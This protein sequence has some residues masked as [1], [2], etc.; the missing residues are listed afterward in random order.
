MININNIKLEYKPVKMQPR[1]NVSEVVKNYTGQT[2]PKYG[3]IWPKSSE[4]N[5]THVH[6]MQQ[7]IPL[8]LNNIHLTRVPSQPTVVRLICHSREMFYFLKAQNNKIVNTR[9]LK[10]TI[11]EKLCVKAL[12]DRWFTISGILCVVDPK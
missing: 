6:N 3:P 10:F 11:F 8:I 5:A 7:Y 9:S 2:R 4:F 12:R 1:S